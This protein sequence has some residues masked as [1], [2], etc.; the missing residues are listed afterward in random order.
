M[1]KAGRG[2]LSFS[3]QTGY[4][5]RYATHVAL[6][7]LPHGV[8][9]LP[10]STKVCSHGSDAPPCPGAHAPWGRSRYPLGSRA[11]VFRYG[12]RFLSRLGRQL[13]LRPGAPARSRHPGQ[14][15]AHGPVPDRGQHPRPGAAPVGPATPPR[16]GKQSRQHPAG[17]GRDRPARR[18]LGDP[19][20]A[21]GLHGGAP[22]GGTLAARARH[23]GGLG[24]PAPA[25]GAAA[26][27][28]RLFLRHGTRFRHERRPGRGLEH[29]AHVP[30]AGGRLARTLDPLLRPARVRLLWP[31]HPAGRQ[32]QPETAPA[33]LGA[34]LRAAPALPAPARH[35]AASG[36]ALFAGPAP[37]QPPVRCQPPSGRSAAT[38]VEHDLPLDPLPIFIGALP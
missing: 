10:T 16:R 6:S 1:A 25:C 3:L 14:G 22:A 32:R 13:R 27:G 8:P 21:L 30:P 20:D 35:A 31:A 23:G 4:L 24:P 12:R 36:P 34:L 29:L 17:P 11:L 15:R 33:G 7:P 19:A 5:G 18:L 37:S 2:S 28:L 26:R 38:G 9:P